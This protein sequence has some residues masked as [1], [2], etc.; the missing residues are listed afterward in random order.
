V[1]RS[2]TQIYVPQTGTIYPSI[3]AASAALGVDAS[4]I[5][6][7]V[8][9][10]R[11]SAG[12]YNFVAVTADIAPDTLKWI[13]QAVEQSLSP[14]QKQRQAKRRK[15]GFGRLSAE[16]KAAAKSRA[17]AARALQ[18]VVREANNLLDQYRKQ[19]LESISVVVPEL[20]KLKDI[21]GRNRKGGFNAGAKNL[22]QFTEREV[23]ALT[24]ALQR[25]LNRKGFK[26][27][28]AAESRKQ[29]IAYQFGLGSPAELDNYADVLPSLWHVLELARATQAKGY[30]RSLY[31]AVSEAMQAGFDPEELKSVLDQMA[32]EH[33]GY[34]E[35]KTEAEEA[36]T[37]I[38]TLDYAELSQKYA[39]MLQ[40][41]E[42]MDEFDDLTGDEWITLDS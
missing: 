7:A 39:D 32:A 23:R 30:D 12:G 22:A 5:G 36:G 4:N 18:G 28:E 11:K 14:Q 31:N 8:R 33:E 1:A 38:P 16:E 15:Q 21:I 9:G 29:G 13:N 37:E 17:K 19:G 6:K 3:S 26:D 35:E 25:Q 40:A 41:Q 10:S 20:E 27:L 42:D 2:R 24:E 34:I